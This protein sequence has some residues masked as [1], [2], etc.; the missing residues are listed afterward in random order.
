MKPAGLP[1]SP[2]AGGTWQPRPRRCSPSRACSKADTVEGRDAL[3][4]GAHGARSRHSVPWRST[5]ARSPASPLTR[6][7]RWSPRAPRTV[8]SGRGTSA[9][10]S[11]WASFAVP[12]SQGVWELAIDPTGTLLAAATG[13]QVR[14][15]DLRTLQ[16]V[17]VLGDA[18]GHPAVDSRL[19]TGWAHDRH[20]HRR[21]ARSTLWDLD[22]AY[23][24]VP[25][26]HGRGRGAQATT[27][28]RWP[29][30][31]T[32]PR[33]AVA[34]SL[35]IE[36][37]L[38]RNL[39]TSTRT[40]PSEPPRNF[41]GV[42]YAADRGL[43]ASESG[44]EEGLPGLVVA[45]PTDGVGPWF[46]LQRYADGVNALA[47]NGEAVVAGRSRRSATVAGRSAT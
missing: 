29:S 2:T 6:R 11:R 46:E 39:I 17:D 45:Y 8:S 14:I 44:W 33:L 38:G 47:V 26:R 25:L 5:T 15:W 28:P 18:D 34:S 32:D 30:T 12:E 9:P 22:A 16:L 7:A 36:W 1:S 41:T 20:R 37:D 31:P 3:A 24:E 40:S 42:G 19:R 23:G 4:R 27:S 10:A 35:L 13:G 21:R 43:I